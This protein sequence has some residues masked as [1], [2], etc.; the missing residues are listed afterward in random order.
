MV[1]LEGPKRRRLEGRGRPCPLAG[2]SLR[3]SCPS[4]ARMQT[5]LRNPCFACLH[6]PAPGH[7]RPRPANVVDVPEVAS[8]GRPE[9]PMPPRRRFA[10]G[11]LP[12][13]H[14]DA[15]VTSQSLLRSSAYAGS[16]TRAAPTWAALSQEVDAFSGPWGQACSLPEYGGDVFRGDASPPIANEQGCQ[17]HTSPSGKGLRHSTPVEVTR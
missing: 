12:F 11:I 9:P 7:G 10:S 3:A 5:S 13:A 16:G 6:T 2:R 15:D 1:Q 17:P 14:S 8:T 4:L